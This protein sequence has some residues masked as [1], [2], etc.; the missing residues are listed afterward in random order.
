[1]MTGAT[2]IYG[3][4][5]MVV[6]FSSGKHSEVFSRIYTVSSHTFWGFYSTFSHRLLK[7][8]AQDDALSLKKWSLAMSYFFTYVSSEEVS[9]HWTVPSYNDVTNLENTYVNIP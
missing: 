6:M 3:N 7:K 2:S 5:P 1:M 4:L 9:D 8:S